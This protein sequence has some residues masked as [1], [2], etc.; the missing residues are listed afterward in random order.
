MNE[1]LRRDANNE[2]V[3]GLVTDDASQEIRM[4]RIDDTTKGLKV[5]V[6]GGEIGGTVTSVSVV[7]ANGISGSIANPTTTPAITLTLGAITPSSV[8]TSGI[9]QG[10]PKKRVI[11]TTQSAT[12]TI[13]TDN[14]DVSNIIGLAQ[15]V[16]SF[17]SN[18]SGTPNPYD[19]L[20]ICITDDGTGR[21]LAWGT[22]FE[23]STISLPST[24]I[25]NTL[26]TIGFLWNSA[27]SKWRCVAIS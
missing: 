18:L 6:V 12:P 11:T 5:M 1:V 10:R 21:A 26:L 16:T 17:T 19:T 23:S 14:T 2:P 13:N 4:G 15:A 7:T 8:I 20:I 25:A 27:T 22:S 9:L 3:I 24:T